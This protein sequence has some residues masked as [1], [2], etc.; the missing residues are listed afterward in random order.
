MGYTVGTKGQVVI[1]KEIRD[2]LGVR[3][4][5]VALQR[6]VNDHL[7]IHFVPP[8]HGNSL[9]GSLA[10]HIKAAPGEDWHKAREGVWEKAAEDKILLEE[11]GS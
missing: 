11:R 3:P 4:G 2:R 7:E 5:W 10:S 8:E 9:K 6:L 1:S